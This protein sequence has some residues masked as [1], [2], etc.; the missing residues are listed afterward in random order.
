VT[1]SRSAASW[2]ARPTRS[3]TAPA[4][5]GMVGGA[6]CL[7]SAQT[8]SGCR[9]SAPPRPGRRLQATPPAPRPVDSLR[10]VRLSPDPLSVFARAME[11]VDHGRG[12]LAEIA[13]DLLPATPAQRRRLVKR[14]T[15][16][17]AGHHSGAERS[18][19]RTS[20]M[21]S[22]RPA[23]GPRRARYPRRVRAA[24]R[25][26]STSRESRRGGPPLPTSRCCARLICWAG[27]WPPV[28]TDGRAIVAGRSDHDPAD[29]RRRAR[30]EGPRP[31]VYR[32]AHADPADL[33]LAQPS[34]RSRRSAGWPSRGW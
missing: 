11:E 28:H 24:T 27:L 26:W 32:R 1:L 4:G 20:S 12:E 6:P 14:L 13:M 8:G 3:L 5:G 34:R 22:R 7:Q 17:G 19:C 23:S 16:Q 29:Q 15:R 33:E 18:C 9:P 31:P 30:P 2:I 25:P 10:K 21:S